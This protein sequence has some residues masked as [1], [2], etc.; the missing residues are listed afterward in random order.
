MLKLFRFQ[1][2]KSLDGLFDYG[3]IKVVIFAIVAIATAV[4]IMGGI[5]YI[6]AEKA[7]VK[8][9]QT[10][11]LVYAAQSIAAKIDG[12]IERAKETSLLLARDPAVIKW[13][14]DGEK[15]EALGRIVKEKLTDMAAEYDYN[16]SFVVSTLTNHYWAEDGMID[17]VSPKD[18]DDS[19]FYEIIVAQNPLEIMIDYNEERKLRRLE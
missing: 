19:W 2:E 12:R 7:V 6:I 17:I 3:V 15:D 8:I 9:V 16:T 1:K 4:L 18:P 13:I 11:E 14:E 5:S 10:K